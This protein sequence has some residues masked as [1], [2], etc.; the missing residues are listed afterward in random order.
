MKLIIQ[1]PCF[2]EAKYLPITLKDLPREIKGIDQIETLVIDDGSRDNTA[3]VAEKNGV[4]HIV[5][6]RKHRGLAAGFSAGLEACLLHGAD[7]IVNTDADNQY[8]GAD[9]PKLIDPILKGQ[10]DIVIGDRQTQ[11][12]KHFS[13]IKKKLQKLGS[14]VVKFLSKTDIL[15]APS[16]FR[17]ISREAALKI[18]VLSN[19]SYTLETLIQAGNIGLS[20][21]SVPI[22]TNEKI[23]DS[24]LFTNLFSFL[25][26]S[27]ST[28]LRSYTMY[29]PL[30][31]FS[32]LSLIFFVLGLIP[33]IRFLYFVYIGQYQGHIQ[34][35]ILTAI[36]L[37]ASF[38]LAVMAVLSDLIASN[39]K[40]IEEI[41]RRVRRIESEESKKNKQ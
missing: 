41:L 23:R 18:N 38:L 10:A 39:R 30:K 17:A 35:L 40:L 22:Q 14:F 27:G 29:K 1:I 12:I 8:R 15:D 16:G 34:S 19:F 37:I 7:I 6:F 32:I 25:K 24:R 26:R 33:G 9:I 31:I 28:I 11:Q 20:V 4:D 3:E 2:N 13:W 21:I 36:L 5:R